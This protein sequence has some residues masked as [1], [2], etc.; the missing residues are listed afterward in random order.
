KGKTHLG[1][2]SAPV[3]A[4]F[5]MNFQAVSV[6][7]KLIKNGVFGGYMDAAG[8]PTQAML[9]EIEF[10][11]GA[12]GQMVDELSKQGLL[13]TTTIIITAKRGQSP[14]D[15]NR[16]FPIPGPTHLNGTAPSKLIAAYLPD[17][18]TSQI[19]PTEDDI[20]LL[21][22]TNSDDTLAAVSVLEDHAAEAQIGQI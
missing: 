1:D 10:V 8:T 12:I 2:E 13:E 9:S 20:S 6:G 17:S 4:I 11:D 16:F 18:E 21:W 5:G 3:P 22:L 15:P 19:G 14:V 7:Q